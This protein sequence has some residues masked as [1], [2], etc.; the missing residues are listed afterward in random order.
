MEPNRVDI[1]V[2]A[3]RPSALVHVDKVLALANGQQIGFGPK[4]EILRKITQPMNVVP[5]APQQMKVAA[6][7]SASMG[8]AS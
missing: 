7:R 2:V 3:H 1:V 8:G 6:E 4:D 5:S